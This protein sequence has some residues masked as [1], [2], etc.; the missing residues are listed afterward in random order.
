MLISLAWKNI[1]RNKIRSGIVMTSISIGLFGGLFICG[2]SRGIIEQRIQSAIE[3]EVSNIQIHHPRFL[4]EKDLEDTIPGAYSIINTLR[5]EPEIKAVSSRIKITGMAQTAAK[6][7]GIN[8]MGIDP[9]AEKKVTG[10]YTFMMDSMGTF[11]GSERKNAIV[12]GKKLAE[13]LK[14]KL[15]SKI[16][17]TIQTDS[18]EITQAAFKITGIFKTYNSAF[19]QS[20]VI[21]RQKDLSEAIGF[22]SFRSH[23]I[24]IA[25]YHDSCSRTIINKTTSRFS[26]LSILPWRKILPE[27]GLMAD[28][29][30]I[31][32]YIIMVIILIALC[33]GIINTMMMAVLE[34]TRELG[35]LMAI[36]MSRYRVFRMIV[37]ET[38]FLSVT[39]AFI[40][41]IVSAGIIN[42][43]DHVGFDLSLFA[44]GLGKI[45]FNAI[46]HPQLDLAFYAGITVLVVILGI[47]SS[48]I[49]AWKAL[50]LNPVEAIRIV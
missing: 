19:D 33:F 6:A 9:E 3:N 21:V 50:K 17:L 8:I 37:L 39:G 2:L 11:F 1:W 31:I 15:N 18:G 41:L 14:V 26:G 10:L 29:T 4:L 38:I 30:N 44:S 43:Y 42:Y 36:G 28:S 27:L 48:L 46:V 23:E 40:G 20:T 12:I 5:N 32:L 35:M 34:R 25:L 47:L 22:K 7:T 16:I 49:P 45:G 24:A 13:L